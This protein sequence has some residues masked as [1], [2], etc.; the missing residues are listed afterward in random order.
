MD[1]VRA[2][3]DVWC[4]AEGCVQ[5]THGGLTQTE[6]RQAA[7]EAGWTHLP[8]KRLN[9]GWLCPEHENV[10]VT[11]KESRSAPVSDG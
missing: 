8:S 9:E 5:W 6:A 7:R 1:S 2:W 10:R 4:D 3:W 11:E